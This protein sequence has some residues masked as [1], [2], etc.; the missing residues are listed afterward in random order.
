MKVLVSAQGADITAQVDPRFG[1]AA[2]FVTVDSDSGQWT[3]QPNASMEA[4]HGA[5][6]ES[7]RF[8]IDQ[9]VEAV[10]TGATG[11]NAFR[12]LRAA[13]VAVYL[14]SAGTV[15]DAV[16]AFRRGALVRSDGAS[17]PAHAGIG[18]GKRSENI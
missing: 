9:G 18:C 2:C 6:I 5:G 16:D 14:V 7:A 8:A 11:P 15:A 12:T 17:A 10:L 4:G 1:R 3:V 13:G